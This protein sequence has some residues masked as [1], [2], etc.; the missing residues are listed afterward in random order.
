LLIV[1]RQYHETINLPYYW[2]FYSKNSFAIFQT[3]PERTGR[4]A[5]RCVLCGE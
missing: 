4:S 1:N 3:P 2:T 5:K